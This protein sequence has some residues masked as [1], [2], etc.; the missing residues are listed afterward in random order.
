MKVDSELSARYRP[1]A[2]RFR[3]LGIPLLAAVLTAVL[4]YGGTEFILD[5]RLPAGPQLE[6]R[7]CAA[8]PTGSPNPDS[9]GARS[10]ESAKVRELDNYLSMAIAAARLVAGAQPGSLEDAQARAKQALR[11]LEFSDDGYFYA[12]QMQDA[13]LVA[14]PHR[15]SEEGRPIDEPD[16]QAL[17][18][19]AQRYPNG[20]LLKY[21]WQRPSTH[22]AAPKVGLVRRLDEWD[23]MVGTGFYP[24]DPEP[25]GL[26]QRLQGETLGLSVAVFTLVLFSM[27]VLDLWRWAAF[28][29]VH[30]SALLALEARE[31]QRISQELHDGLLQIL[32]GVRIHL[33]QLITA[34]HHDAPASAAQRAAVRDGLEHIATGVDQATKE[35]RAIALAHSP[36]PLKC[37]GLVGAIERLA[38]ELHRT[39]GASAEFS[40][41]CARPEVSEEVS[42]ACYRVAQEALR[43]VVKHSRSKRVAIRLEK[44]PSELLLCVED[45]GVGR[46]DPEAAGDGLGLRNMAA[47]VEQ[48]GGDLQLD[49]RPGQTRVVAR[50]TLGRPSLKTWLGR[51]VSRR[52]KALLSERNQNHANM[53]QRNDDRLAP[54]RS[55]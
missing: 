12:Y 19:C 8:G 53:P 40:T 51:L 23:W 18:E 3:W 28:E 14:H 13:V 37:Y 30:A 9:G 45:D 54:R 43:N 48:A 50:F 41:N 16:V 44:S 21:S 26:L 46:P 35:T 32:S 29:R 17:I 36:V 5:S 6:E 4:V 27:L 24:V 31:R 49:S 52:R 34:G 7:T 55:P 11:Q 33:G 10:S 15:R 25:E 47:R 38:A 42:T 39:H 22:N 1:R 2:W 20:G